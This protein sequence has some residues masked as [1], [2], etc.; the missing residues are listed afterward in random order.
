MPVP[1]PKHLLGADRWGVSRQ[2]CDRSNSQRGKFASATGVF[3]LVPHL[4]L[5]LIVLALRLHA[6][7]PSDAEVRAEVETGL[8]RCELEEWTVGEGDGACAYVTLNLHCGGRVRSCEVA[9]ESTRGGWVVSEWMGIERCR[10]S[11][12]R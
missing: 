2:V 11:R 1:A 5:L 10:R 6:C 9:F 12:V 7:G 4:G 8:P 3:P